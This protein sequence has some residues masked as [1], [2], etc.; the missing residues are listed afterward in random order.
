MTLLPRGLP[1]S[2]IQHSTH[3]IRL[4]KAEV[5]LTSLSGPGVVLSG[6]CAGAKLPS[7]NHARRR[8]ATPRR[9]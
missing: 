1:H 8:T 2:A 5:R 3:M 7:E 4:K 6:K 9:E